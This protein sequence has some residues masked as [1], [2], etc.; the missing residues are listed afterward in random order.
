MILCILAALLLPAGLP[1]AHADE[2]SETVLTLSEDA[3]D[4]EL[5]YLKLRL[6]LRA[7]DGV[8][9]TYI[10]LAPEN[11][12]F[13]VEVTAA[14]LL[15][16]SETTLDLNGASL[17]RT[18]ECEGGNMLQN[19]D[20]NGER[21]S[22]GGYALTKNITVKNGTLDGNGDLP[23]EGNNLVN[24]GH[25]D[26]VTMTDL[27]LKNVKGA[28]LIELSG[29]KNCRIENCTFSGK[30]VKMEALQLDVT[31]N[32]WNGVY[33]EDNTPCRDVTVT[34]CTFLDA[35]SGTGNHHALTGYI[36]NENINIINNTFL[37]TIIYEEPL[38]AIWCYG[39]KNCTV[40]GN[41]IRGCYGTGIRVSGGTAQITENEIDL[42]GLPDSSG[43]YLTSANCISPEDM[44]SE[45]RTPDPVADALI[46]NNTVKNY[47]RNG[48][49]INTG[50]T[51]TQISGNT[52]TD[53]GGTGIFVSQSAVTGITGNMVKGCKYVS[54]D[55]AGHGIHVT[56]TGS[57]AELTKNKISGC[58]GYGIA[59]FQADR[60]IKAAGN[61]LSGNA[62][63]DVR[64]TYKPLPEP[65][66]GGYFFVPAPMTAGDLL[67]RA[68]GLRV[69]DETAEVTADAQTVT[70]MRLYT[71]THVYTL[72]LRGDLTGDG[73]V[74]TA[75]A[76]QALRYA[77]NLDTPGETD[78]LSA[79]F[80]DPAAVTVADARTILRAAV[81][82]QEIPDLF[83][84]V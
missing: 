16:K 71:E 60:S 50:S 25:A 56:S 76:R 3:A 58:A 2:G 10:R 61:K 36:Y 15:M 47:G 84:T 53:G 44:G 82:L 14:S 22:A 30:D 64:I 54:E 57:A 11:G 39:M 23:L 1:A 65:V 70:G 13:Y 62:L 40:R 43:I 83:G 42:Q 67:K 12:T 48:I 38:P 20:E 21:L 79:A 46:S 66:E 73:K 24:F 27:T 19:G 59:C 74:S 45:A 49:S 7:A 18:G 77:V 69:T 31:N 35:P 29:C 34:G 55:N 78:I 26:G 5:N 52:V 9:P 80:E 28:H 51:V 41:V 4:A 68:D 6:A 8:T 72:I 17:I 33:L 63:G 75:D 81:G 32:E 37:N